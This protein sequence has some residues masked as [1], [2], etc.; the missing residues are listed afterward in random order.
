MSVN[1]TGSP[2]R[3]WSGND[4]TTITSNITWP[5]VNL[6]NRREPPVQTF[7]DI[8]LEFRK[9]FGPVLLDNDPIVNKFEMR[10]TFKDFRQPEIELELVW[11]P[12][13]SQRRMF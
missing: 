2:E 3:L 12:K 7:N 6:P 11:V 9:L 4:I 5:A 13:K 10:H 8:W 1:T